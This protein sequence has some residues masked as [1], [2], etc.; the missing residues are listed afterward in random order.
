M[1]I[2]INGEGLVGT[3]N[4]IPSKSDVHRALICAALS[5]RKSG[6]L[7]SSS[8]EDIDATVRCLNALGA[9]IFLD[10]NGA[11]VEPVGE[12]LKFNSLLDCGESGSTLRFLLPVS[13]ALGANSEF[14]GK[15][16]LG[17]RPL[18]PLSSLMK[19]HGCEILNEG[20]FPITAKG[21]M[22][23]GKFKLA[24][25]VSSQF[26]TG[27]LFAL[28][29]SGGGEIEV[30]PPVESQKYIDMTVDVMRKFGIDVSVNGNI[31][32]VPKIS[33]YKIQNENYIADGDWSNGAFFLSAGAIKGKV[34]V[35]GLKKNSLQGDKKI[36]EIL[37][38]FGAVVEQKETSVTVK[39]A[40]LKGIEVD[41]SQIPDLVPIIS[42]VAAFAEGKTRIYNASRLRLK[43]SDRLSAMA[44]VLSAIGAEVEE[45][46][47]SLIITGNPDKFYSGMADSFNDHRVAMS[48]AVAAA[49]GGNITI[50]NAQ[51][52]NKSYPDFY[53]DLCLL[54]G[55]CN[56]V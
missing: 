38:R 28:P 29:I 56:V 30:L 48:L 50:E 21:K 8:S 22:A 9:K 18:E 53:K 19:E 27:L 3:V 5:N 47:D 17:E 24:G 55:K 31:Y 54:G 20:S 4:A 45:F 7:F 14:T 12:N 10:E 37:E 35:N 1:R 25:N 49:C 51:A 11:S 46:E 33:C 26:I 43:E 2:N 15:G 36:L 41:A 34:I 44:T 40:P 6:I 42:V 23:G 13:A 52:V 39:S 16:R 32:T